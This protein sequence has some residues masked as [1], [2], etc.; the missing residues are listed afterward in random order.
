MLGVLAFG[1]GLVCGVVLSGFSSLG[2]LKGR[3]K[4]VQLSFPAV[5][6]KSRYFTNRWMP[7]LTGVPLFTYPTMPLY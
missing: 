2:I 6:P 7:N 3:K 4:A 5:H 1:T